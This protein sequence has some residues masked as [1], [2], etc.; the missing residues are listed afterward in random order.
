MI[1]EV[2]ISEIVEKVENKEINLID[3]RETFEYEM[4]HVP[5]AYNIPL[6]EF[7]SRYKDMDKNYSYHI[8]CQSGARSAQAVEFLTQQGY[9]ATNVAGGTA[10]WTGQLEH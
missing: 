4:G 7:V 10:A 3:V 8:I 6:S 9:D 2:P 5:G 1:K